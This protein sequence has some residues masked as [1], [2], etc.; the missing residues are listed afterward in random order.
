MVSFW[1]QK[2]VGPRPDW[3]P[4]GV[5]LKFPTSIPAPFIWESTLGAHLYPYFPWVPLSLPFSPAAGILASPGFA[6]SIFRPIQPRFVVE[7]ERASQSQVD[8]VRKIL[9]PSLTLLGP[10]QWYHCILPRCLKQLFWSRKVQVNTS[11][12]GTLGQLNQYI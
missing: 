1:G 2:R 5:N 7:S 10:P 6:L 11:P 4:L 3:S 8:G 12:I 9:L